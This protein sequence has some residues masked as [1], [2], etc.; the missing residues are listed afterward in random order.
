MTLPPPM[1]ALLRLARAAVPACLV[2]ACAWTPEP[3]AN[4]ADANLGPGRS[5]FEDAG[6]T[7]AANQGGMDVAGN[8][9]G[10]DSLSDAA[11]SPPESTDASDASAALCGDA[12][13]GVG[14]DAG[15]DA[16]PDAGQNPSADAAVDASPPPVDGAV[17][18]DV[19]ARGT[20]DPADG[21]PAND[22]GCDPR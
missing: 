5:P 22:A 2:V 7:P 17:A 3:E 13:G 14:A 21:G 4:G 6:G 19:D 20:E 18:P 11:P 1:S 10:I 15:P 12:D 9:A 8:D 16:G